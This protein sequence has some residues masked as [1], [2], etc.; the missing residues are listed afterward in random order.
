MKSIRLLNKK[1]IKIDIVVESE[2]NLD[3][4]LVNDLKTA[5]RKVAK[6]N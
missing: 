2:S 5:E 4:I 3:V 6:S 1:S